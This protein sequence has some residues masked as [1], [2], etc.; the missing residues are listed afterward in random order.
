LIE[1]VLRSNDG[2]CAL[3]LIKAVLLLVHQRSVCHLVIQ[4]VVNFYVIFHLLKLC[5]ALEKPVAFYSVLHHS[6]TFESKGI[7][8][9][10]ILRQSTKTYWLLPVSESPAAGVSVFYILL[11][12][13]LSQIQRPYQ[14]RTQGMKKHKVTE[15]LIH[16]ASK[17]WN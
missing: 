6:I 10:S 14:K 4:L 16:D 13:C 8:G 5:S 1:S 17:G 12:T 15:M 3:H 9:R 2:K 7:P 11:I